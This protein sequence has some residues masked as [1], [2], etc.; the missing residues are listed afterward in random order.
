[1]RRDYR[2]HIG[3]NAKGRSVRFTY[4]EWNHV[5]ICSWSWRSRLRMLAVIAALAMVSS[6]SYWK[7]TGFD[8]SGILGALRKDWF[9]I[10]SL[11]IWVQLLLLILIHQLLFAS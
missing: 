3:D 4:D 10:S 11:T 6:F 8:P 9:L 2:A 7:F 5:L 1:M